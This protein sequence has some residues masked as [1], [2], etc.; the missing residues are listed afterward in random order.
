MTSD[1]QPWRPSGS[2]RAPGGL[3][4]VAG[5]ALAGLLF[6]WGVPGGM[7]MLT[8]LVAAVGAA[9]F[10]AI[11][12]GYLL[13]YRLALGGGVL[14]VVGL[15]RT[16][17]VPLQHVVRAYPAKS[18]MV[19]LL[20]DGRRIRARAVET[21]A[22]RRWPQPAT[23]V[24]SRAATSTGPSHCAPCLSTT[25]V[26]ARAAERFIAVVAIRVKDGARPTRR[27]ISARTP[28]IRATR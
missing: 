12:V 2:V 20:D 11:G 5:S 17:R 8:G 22:C 27:V 26:V 14:T 18:G 16:R 25:P 21:A 13:R 9:A 19:I 7:P 3:L 24:P 28:V 23:I 1:V 6:S 10:A 4:A 15:W